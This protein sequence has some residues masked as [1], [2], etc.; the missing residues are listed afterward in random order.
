[1]CVC[2][3]YAYRIRYCTRFNS[4]DSKVARFFL[5]PSIRE[6]WEKIKVV[7]AGM[8]GPSP[9]GLNRAMEAAGATVP[10]LLQLT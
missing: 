6:N 10:R 5:D 2:V 7:R 4:R 3:D 9:G 8:N 1:M